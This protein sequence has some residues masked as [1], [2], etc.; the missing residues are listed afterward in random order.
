LAALHQLALRGDLGSQ[1]VKRAMEE[2]GIRP[3]KPNP[4]YS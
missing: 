4:V 3:E 2:L 1:V